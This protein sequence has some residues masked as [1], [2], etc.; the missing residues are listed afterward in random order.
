MVPRLS[1]ECAFIHLE[2]RVR[3][4]MPL[5]CTT[6]ALTLLIANVHNKN[7]ETIAIKSAFWMRR[8]SSTHLL[9][10]SVALNHFLRI[11]HPTPHLQQ[12]QILWRHAAQVPRGPRTIAVVH[13]KLITDDARTRT[14]ERKVHQF[15]QRKG[16]GSTSRL[17]FLLHFGRRLFSSVVGANMPW[18]TASS[19]AHRTVFT[20]SYYVAAGICSV[21]CKLHYFDQYWPSVLPMRSEGKK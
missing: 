16:C 10:F 19:L 2:R 21:P 9:R 13:C 6:L 11:V 4:Q 17:K 3:A 8:W 14:N 18:H 5:A 20:L 1:A 7:V 15:Q 12:S